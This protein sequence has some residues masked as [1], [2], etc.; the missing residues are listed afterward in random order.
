M[1]WF[2][3]CLFDCLAGRA[4]LEQISQLASEVPELDRY[5]RRSNAD[6]LPGVRVTA[7]SAAHFSLDETS[8]TSG[9]GFRHL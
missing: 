7:M 3:D 8:S 6:R 1:T 4:G 9:S 5:L 2:R